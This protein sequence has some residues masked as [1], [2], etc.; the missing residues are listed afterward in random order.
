MMDASGTVTERRLWSPLVYGEARSRETL[1]ASLPGGRN[2]LA[3]RPPASQVA[4]VAVSHERAEQ[5]P[6]LSEAETV[7]SHLAIRLSAYP[8]TCVHVQLRCIVT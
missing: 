2:A 5:A 1:V 8:L 6:I 3:L 4:V 7:L